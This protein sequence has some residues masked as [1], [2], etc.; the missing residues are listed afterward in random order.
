MDF[1]PWRQKKSHT[2]HYLKAPTEEEREAFLLLGLAAKKFA[3]KEKKS[4]LLKPQVEWSERKGRERVGDPLADSSKRCR[5]GPGTNRLYI[6]YIMYPNPL[7]VQTRWPALPS[8]KVHPW[9]RLFFPPS[10]IPSGAPN[11]V[12]DGGLSEKLL[13]TAMRPPEVRGTDAGVTAKG[14]EKT[15]SPPFSAVG[16]P[17][18]QTDRKFAMASPPCLNPST[19]GRGK[20]FVEAVCL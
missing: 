18:C 15:S 13:C 8:G 1:A 9:R 2:Y 19:E 7:P 16:I 10:S 3:S 4:S 12:N 5:E 14:A 11:C 20:V 17:L 6:E